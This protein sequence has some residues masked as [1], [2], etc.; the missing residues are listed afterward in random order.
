MHTAHRVSILPDDDGQGRPD[1]E[2][3]LHG[4]CRTAV[5]LQIEATWCSKCDAPPFSTNVYKCVPRIYPF[6]CIHVEIK[7][8]YEHNI[9][10]H[11]DRHLAY[12][13]SV[14]N[15]F[16]G[17][18]SQTTYVDMACLKS[19]VPIEVHVSD[20]FRSASLRKY[21]LSGSMT[22]GEQERMEEQRREMHWQGR[23]DER[24]SLEKDYSE[25][26]ISVIQW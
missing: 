5:K 25:L 11:V 12:I 7:Y 15:C 13:S 17:G 8:F 14:S 19:F 23:R 6:G 20:S 3:P 21:N 16:T 26:V 2:R 22:Q 1:T 10:E 18:F 4:C 9:G 24:D